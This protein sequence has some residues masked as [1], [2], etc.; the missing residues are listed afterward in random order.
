LVE[1]E[2][3]NFGDG[4]AHQVATTI[5]LPGALRVTNVEDDY[6]FV[7]KEG[8]KMWIC[9]STEDFLVPSASIVVPCRI[10]VPRGTERVDFMLTFGERD[11]APTR[12]PLRLTV[13]T[14]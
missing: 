3:H 1:C 9:G 2:V 12:V 10:R 8:E 11:R 6:R 13:A 14:E 7:L 5:S 4:S